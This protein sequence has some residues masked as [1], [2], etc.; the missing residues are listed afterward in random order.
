MSTK[1]TS[2][3]IHETRLDPLS[4]ELEVT[5][6]VNEYSESLVLKGRLMGPRCRYAETVEIAYPLK[7][8]TASD[9]CF[10]GRVII[11]EPSFWEPKS[12]FF[13]VGPI[14][15][16]ENGQRIDR[17]QVNHG[18]RTYHV[19]S[20]SFILN[21]HPLSLKGIEVDKLTEQQALTL[22]EEGYNVLVVPVKEETLS[23]WSMAN[24][25]GFFIVA[26]KCADDWKIVEQH[27]SHLGW[28]VES[29]NGS[30][31]GNVNDETISIEYSSSFTFSD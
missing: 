29:I 9:H 11:P 4:T 26:K 12:P 14:E 13:Y 22:R 1:I 19:S 31:I 24:Q 16:W 8:I 10:R 28:H 2:A 15:L 20:T 3:E 6:Q 21:G 5:V 30:I 18:L 7:N 17:V 25:L 23:L 27:S